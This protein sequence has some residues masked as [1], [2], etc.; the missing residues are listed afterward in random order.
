MNKEITIIEIINKIANREEVPQKI[1]YIDKIYIY[2]EE[3]QDYLDIEDEFYLLG[4]TFS[5]LRKRDFINDKV[6]ILEEYE[7][8]YIEELENYPDISNWKY[9]YGIDRALLEQSEFNE[10]VFNRLN[11]L[12]KEVNKLRKED[13]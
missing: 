11:E 9:S 4:Y 2:T 3:N 5:N 10:K 6:E 13:K 12:A 1:K 7:D 8:K